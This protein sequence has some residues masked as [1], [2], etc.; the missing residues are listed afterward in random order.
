MSFT[1]SFNINVADV[2][3]MLTPLAP[4]AVT[5]YWVSATAHSSIAARL[6]GAIPLRALPCR[7][8]LPPRLA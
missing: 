5:G 7:V 8:Q 4:I 6:K 2:L 1:V 3:D